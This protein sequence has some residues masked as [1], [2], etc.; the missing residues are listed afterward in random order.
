MTLPSATET[1]CRA[2]HQR[3]NSDSGD[4]EYFTP[5]FIIEAARLCMGGIDLD[6]ASSHAANQRVKAKVYFDA[7]LDGLGQ[8]WAHTT[9]YCDD[10]SSGECVTRPSRLWLNHPFSREGNP[11]WINKLTK[12]F[13]AGDVE[14]ACC[15]TFAATSEKW[16]QPLLRCCQC[17]L[18]PRTNYFMPD[19]TIKRGV[20]KGSVVTYLGNRT[21]AFANAFREL[22]VVKVPFA[23]IPTI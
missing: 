2:A 10:R 3:I 4:T 20:T 8:R 14:Q 23:Y 12:S 6:P 9:L 21:D 16:F 18:T 13:Y 15:I 1:V 22:G 19:G 7:E 17:F 5:Q 11:L